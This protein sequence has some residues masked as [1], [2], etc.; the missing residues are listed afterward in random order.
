MSG[1]SESVHL[2]IT[3]SLP[4]AQQESIAV[5]WESPVLGVRHSRFIPPYQGPVLGLV[6]RALELAQSLHDPRAAFSA[7]EQ[8]QLGILGLWHTGGW[9]VPDACQRIGRTLYHALAADPEGAAALDTVRDYA[10]A[11]NQ[12]L[13]LNLRLPPDAVHLAALPWE[14]LWDEGPVPLLLSRGRV[15]ACTRYL[16]LAQALPPPRP[17]HTPLRVLVLAPHAGIAEHV[18]RSEQQARQAAWKPLVESGH[19]HV[20]EISLVTRQVLVDALQ[21]GPTPDVI[22]YYGH[23][24]YEAGEGALLLD[25]PGGGECW[26]SASS[27]MPLFGGVRMVVLFACQ[28]ASV[29]QAQHVLTGVAPALSAAGVPVVVGMQFSVRVRAATRASSV[30]YR[31]LVAGWSV[32][33]AVSLIRQALYVEE[34]DRASWYVPVVYIRAQDTAP[35]FLLEPVAARDGARGTQPLAAY[36]RAV[37]GAQQSVVARHNSRIRGVAAQ[38]GSGAQQNIAASH[39]GIIERVRLRAARAGNQQVQAEEASEIADINLE[40]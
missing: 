11:H 22:H 15:A 32:Q 35:V 36:Q 21:S 10:T 6:V 23:G 7:A 20:N 30:M 13:A 17:Q 4:D 31:A 19:M 28:G 33:R 14:L 40:A 1:H 8:A 38:G 39:R 27:L 5:R 16:D 3:F 26:T 25:A 37:G 34:N 2:S 9:L 29:G 18:R 12:A 24:R